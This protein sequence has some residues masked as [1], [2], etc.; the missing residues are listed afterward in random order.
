MLKQTYVEKI[1]DASRVWNFALQ[2][3]RAVIVTVS[4]N[5]NADR[6][7]FITDAK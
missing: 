7:D 2:K 3:I 4:Q 1:M 5:V 6:A